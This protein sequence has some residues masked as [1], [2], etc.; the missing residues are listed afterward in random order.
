MPYET[1]SSP[2]A[3]NGHSPSMHG[4]YCPIIKR[5]VSQA[6]SPA[7]QRSEWMTKSKRTHRE[8]TLWQR[9]FFEHQIRDEMDFQRHVEYIHHN[10]VKHGRCKQVTEWPYSTFHRYVEHGIY[11]PNWAG[12]D[13]EIVIAGE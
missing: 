3:A 1:H 7:Y 2:F 4:Y 8:S 9:R 5:Q 10:P 13:E 11:P 12:G 6:C